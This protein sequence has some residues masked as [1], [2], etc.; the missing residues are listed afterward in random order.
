MFPEA[1]VPTALAPSIGLPSPWPVGK[2]AATTVAITESVAVP[3]CC[4]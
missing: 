4:R 2:F 3:P 1:S